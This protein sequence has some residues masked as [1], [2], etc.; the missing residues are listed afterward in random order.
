MKV[1]GY[2]DLTIKLDS[3]VFIYSDTIGIVAFASIYD[4]FLKEV[5]TLC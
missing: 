5:N 2:L 3:Q 4:I 1:A